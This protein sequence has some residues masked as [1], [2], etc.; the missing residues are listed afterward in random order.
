MDALSEKVL[1]MMDAVKL[2][3]I[4]RFTLSTSGSYRALC[5]NATQLHEDL[6]EV[7]LTH[8]D[9]EGNGQA[10]KHFLKSLEIM[11]DQ[12]GAKHLDRELIEIVYE[13]SLRHSGEFMGELAFFCRSR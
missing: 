7:N 5:R 1:E 3:T 8:E 6:D 9:L 10:F 11:K 4:R 13:E 2:Y 12:Y